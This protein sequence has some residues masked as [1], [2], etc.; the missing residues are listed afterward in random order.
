M[1]KALIVIG[2]LAAIVG[3]GV[4]VVSWFRTPEA[5][6]TAAARPWP[7]GLGTLDTVA[8]RY[9]KL[10]ANAASAQLTA[11]AKTL[12]NELITHYVEHEIARGELVIG[13]PP[14]LPDAT[15]I[16]ELLLHEPIVWERH[17]GIDHPGTM[18]MRGVQMNVARALIASALAKGRANDAAAWDDL[19]ATWQLARALDAH[20]QMMAQTAALST[21]RMINAVAWK[22]PLPAPAWF[23]EVQTR[24]EIPTLLR[25]FQFQASSYWADGAH[26]FP[27]KWLANSV[28][29]DRR[30]AETVA[31]EKRC[32]VSAPMND[33]GVDVSSV[34]RRAFR[35]RAEREAT[36]NALRV[37]D[38]KPIETKSQC[39]DGAW[40]F[41]GT[42]LRFTRAIT[43]AAPDAPMPL[44]LKL[45]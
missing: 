4:W 1:K 25:S 20:P 26:S 19:H 16:R 6:A 38:G 23:A 39:S 28:E 5:V 42:T 14:K 9:P 21:A 18:N 29:N 41:D 32:D 15:A 12:P 22:M 2:I 33:L 37:R 30:I 24:D 17:E 11:L 27:T 35:Y 44:V 7:G 13:A 36:A 43:T 10:P 8:A 3:I 31:N 40:T 45:K 34:W